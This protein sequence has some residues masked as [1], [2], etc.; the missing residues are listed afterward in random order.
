MT[1]D[2]KR[3]VFLPPACLETP[4]LLRSLV[5]GFFEK[6]GFSKEPISGSVVVFRS[7]TKDVV[8]TCKFYSY[9]VE[10]L[11]S[12]KE[13]EKI[14]RKVYGYLFSNCVAEPEVAFIVPLDRS[15]NPVSIYFESWENVH[16]APSID[17][18][19]AVFPLLSFFSVHL[20]G[21][22][23]LEALLLSPLLS[24]LA[25]LLVRLWLRIRAVRVDEGSVV[26]V[27]AKIRQ[28]GTTSENVYFAKLDLI[29]SLR[30][31]EGL[32]KERVAKV[33]H[34]WGILTRDVELKTY[35]FRS[36]FEKLKLRKPPSIFLLDDKR[37]T[38]LSLGL[39]P[40]IALTPALLVDLSEEE[41]A[42]VLVHEAAHI[43]HRD[44]LRA[45]LLITSGLALGAFIYL[46]S[47][48]IELLALYAVASYIL[49][50]MLLKSLEIRAD[51][52]AAEA[53]P[54]AYRKVLVK[55]EY[56]RLVKPTSMLGIVASILNVFSYPPP[57]VRLKII[58]EG[59]SGKGAVAVAKCLLRCYLC[60]GG[61]EGK[62]R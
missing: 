12:H 16:P 59:C 40:A 26:V 33:L 25:L 48:S 1:A 22:R 44:A 31:K 47:Y 28:V 11:S 43:R 27:K 57:T 5:E 2:K 14:S 20:I 21:V 36:I 32:S 50:S 39:P 7:S 15:G 6:N 13:L 10:L 38:A 17:T 23:L 61:V 55:L 45:L 35:D 8:V 56:P 62:S 18:V 9:K 42:S 49:T 51:L 29:S 30:R 41:L 3:E 53:F 4:G 24:I 58:E 34:Y 19:A 46:S 60:G 37:R 54:E 52:E